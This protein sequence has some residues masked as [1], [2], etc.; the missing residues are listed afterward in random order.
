VGLNHCANLECPSG[1]ELGRSSCVCSSTLEPPVDGA[2]SDD[3]CGP[4]GCPCTLDGIEG[5]IARGGTQVLRCVGAPPVNSTRT[6]VVDND[7]I[8]DGQEITVQGDGRHLIFDVEPS[9]VELIGFTIS[10]GDQAIAVSTGATLTLT[11]STVKENTSSSAGGG[12]RND[13]ILTLVDTTVEANTAASATFGSGGG[14]YNIGMLTLTANSKVRDNESFG[15]PG[16]GIQNDGGEVVVEGGSEISSN[17]AFAT[18]PVGRLNRGGGISNVNGTV[19]VRNS[20]IEGNRALGRGGGLSSTGSS[21]QTQIIDTTVSRNTSKGVGGGFWGEDGGF[22]QATR[23][24]WLENE[25]E[26]DGGAILVEGSNTALTLTSSTVWNN[27]APATGV[28]GAVRVYNNA[29]ATIVNSTIFDNFAG[30]GGAL[31]IQ[32]GASAEL[33]SSTISRNRASGIN[34]NAA[35]IT[36]IDGTLTL[37]Q[38]IIDDSC[39]ALATT[40]S[41][42]YNIESPGNTCQLDGTNDMV[43]VTPEALALS[44]TLTE[45]VGATPTLMMTSQSVAVDSMI[46]SCDQMEDQRGVSRPQGLGCDIG[47]VELRPDE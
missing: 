23:T 13:G 31:H 9:I 34:G 41:L 10:N 8:L 11:N 17:K 26:F 1:Q 2:C 16:G 3:V 43:D 4:D 12:I 29:N 24:K 22:L 40:V 27:S 20:L 32:L 28:G 19:T 25:S 15:G 5:A 36:N 21:A 47:A 30:D 39:V 38:T 37:I 46:S 6:I 7:V 14:I 45:N 33:R 35:G 18:D 42:D 44:G